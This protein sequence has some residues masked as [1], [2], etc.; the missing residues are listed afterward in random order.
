MF[1]HGGGC[2]DVC[3]S[4]VVVILSVSS[5]NTVTGESVTA[6][7]VTRSAVRGALDVRVGTALAS[8]MV[9]HATSTPKVGVRKMSQDGHLG[10]ATGV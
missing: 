10:E 6:E 1:Y 3:R 8:D 4:P 5:A 2:P 9:V 7:S